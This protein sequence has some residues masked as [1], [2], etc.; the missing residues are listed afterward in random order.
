MP[1]NLFLSLRMNCHINNKK[2]TSPKASKYLYKYLTKG[3]DQAMV[4]IQVEGQQQDEISQYEDL[5][6]FESS[7]AAWHLMG[8]PIARR[9]PPVQTLRVQT[10]DQQQL[11]KTRTGFSHSLC[12]TDSK[13]IRFISE[14]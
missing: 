8:F 7:E 6:S 1:Y 9:Y 2:C 10:E 14:I 12:S 13:N 5:R 4:A 3:S 11:H